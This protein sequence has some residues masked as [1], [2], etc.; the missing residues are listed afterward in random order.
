M[1]QRVNGD[2]LGGHGRAAGG[3]PLVIEPDAPFDG[4]AG[5]SLPGRSWEQRVAGLAV[6]FG[7][8]GRWI[9]AP[10]SG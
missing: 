5:Q 4:V 9:S 6:L 10:C 1:P 8:P 7:E 2:V 3:R